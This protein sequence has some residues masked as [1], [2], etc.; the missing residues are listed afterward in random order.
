MTG[1]SSRGGLMLFLS[2]TLPGTKPGIFWFILIYFHTLPLSYSGSP[3]G[4]IINCIPWQNNK[5]KHHCTILLF[6]WFELVCFANKNKKLSI[7]IQ[8]IPNHSYRRSMVQLYPTFSI[9]C[10]IPGPLR[11]KLRL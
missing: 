8:L 4:V 9:P 5:G 11:L 6:D 2:L 3:I 1:I 10:C 7:V